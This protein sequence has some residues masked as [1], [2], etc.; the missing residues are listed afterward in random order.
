M[1]YKNLLK[2]V[3]AILLGIV[4]GAGLSTLTDIV[5]EAVGVLPSFQDQITKGLYI[6]WL[7]ALAILYRTI[8]T[9]FSGYLTAA[10]APNKP[11]VH[12]WIIGGIAFA[13][14][15]AGT[16]LTWG[17]GLGPEW[18]PITLTIL[19]FPSVWLGAKLKLKYV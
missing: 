18:Y 4:V 5:L 11:W 13:A 7:L 16:I 9:I 10:L 19:A 17:K 1:N 6:W 14:N 15:L 2:S 12:V 3:G 8:Y